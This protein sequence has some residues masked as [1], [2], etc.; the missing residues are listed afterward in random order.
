MP[1]LITLS[2]FP[3]IT[4]NLKCLNHFGCFI[5]KFLRKYNYYIG[6]ILLMYTEL[7]S[8]KGYVCIRFCCRCMARLRHEKVNYVQ[9]FNC[10][11]FCVC[12]GVRVSGLFPGW[13]GT[14]TAALRAL[15][16]SPGNSGRTTW[17]SDWLVYS[18]PDLQR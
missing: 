1:C 5:I 6:K 10:N 2:M 7:L 15:K 14:Q 9:N 12:G 16:P 3:N 11:A 13:N 4:I 17:P 8:G 18:L